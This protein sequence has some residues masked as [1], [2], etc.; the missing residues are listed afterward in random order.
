VTT[1]RDCGQFLVDRK[2]VEKRFSALLPLA[3]RWAARQERRIRHRGV[4]LTAS[5]IDDAIAVG[6]QQPQNVRLLA[7]EQVPWPAA[8][9]L[10]PAYRA[11]GF[12]TDATRG[13]TLRYGIFIRADCWR[14]RDLIMHELVHTAQYERLGG[15]EPFL[16]VYLTE[17]LTV[18][19]NDAPLECEAVTATTERLK[20][21]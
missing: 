15:I 21:A 4:P 8:S 10:R 7:V 1:R 5:E 6:V 20:P 11:V 3:A 2:W 12:R 16:R 14:N 17:C 13:L 18:G 9:V 19:Y